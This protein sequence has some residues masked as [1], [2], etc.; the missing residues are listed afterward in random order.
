MLNAHSDYCCDGHHPPI[1]SCFQIGRVQPDI[2]PFALKG[3]VEEGVDA[4]VDVLTERRHLAFGYAAHADGLHEVVDLVCGGALDPCFLDHGHQRPLAGATRLKEA[5][6]I[7]AFAQRGDFQMEGAQ[8]YLEGALA[9]PVAL[10]GAF[11]GALIARGAD[12]VVHVM[13]HEFLQH[14]AGEIPQE[15]TAIQ[16]LHAIK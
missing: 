12:E 10:G 8:P 5:G 13:L 14:G 3:A 6:E 4:A 16:L 7:G 2:G 1:L 9:E 11:V 15:I